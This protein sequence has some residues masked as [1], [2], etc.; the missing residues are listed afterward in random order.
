MKLTVYNGSPRGV[1]SNTKVLLSSFLAGFAGTPGNSFEIAYLISRTRSDEHVRLFGEAECVL[2]AFPLYHD[3]MPA[4]VKDF[5]ED[6]A[7]FCGRANNPPLAFIVQ[8]GFVE[9]VHSEAVER[10]LA[11]LSVRLGCEYKGTVIRGAGEAVRIVSSQ[12]GFVGKL[13][14]KFSGLTN[15]AGVGH[16]LDIKKLRRSFYD[17]GTTFGR[18]GMLD[19][20]IVAALARPRTISRLSFWFANTVTN[21]LY[22]NRLLRSNGAYRKRYRRPYAA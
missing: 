4:P 20:K 8:S 19:Q 6:L 11:R 1:H 21:T 9:S 10:Y 13:I 2:I 12:R 17:L 14:V 15:I 22:W 18:T 3:S 5:I 16:C 7:A